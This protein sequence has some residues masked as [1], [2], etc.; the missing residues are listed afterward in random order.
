VD[1]TRYVG[2]DVKRS[3]DVAFLEKRDAEGT[4]SDNLIDW[5]SGRCA[6]TDRLYPE[7]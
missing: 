5:I 3:L 7:I 2:D 6:Q 4:A 1:Q